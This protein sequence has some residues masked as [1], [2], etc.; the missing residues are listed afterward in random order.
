MMVRLVTLLAILVVVSG[1]VT[2]VGH[3]PA[4]HGTEVKL[5]K[6]NFTVQDQG[7]VGEA[8]VM[9]LFGQFQQILA[10]YMGPPVVGSVNGIAFGDTDLMAQAA[11]NLKAN[12]GVTV[13]GKKHLVNMAHDYKT[14]MWIPLILSTES[15]K[16]TADVIEYK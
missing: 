7:V 1:C 5:M 6:N 12:S 9:V 4:F 8:N 2:A 15:V 16:L 14:T 13:G 3:G 11:E 10:M